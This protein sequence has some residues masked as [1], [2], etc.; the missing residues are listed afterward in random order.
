MRLSLKGELLE[1]ADP[2]AV[3]A[4]C[5]AGATMI[6]NTIHLFDE[7]IGRFAAEL[8]TDLS[9]PVNVNMYLSQ[10]SRPAFNRH[11]DIHDV[12]I[13]QIDGHKGWAVYDPTVNFPLFEMKFHGAVPPTEPRIETEL[14]PGDVLYIPRGHWHEATA[15]EDQSLHLT[16]GIDA[17]TGIDFLTWVINELREDADCRAPF[18]LV[19]REEERTEQAYD[20]RRA[21][22]R[23]VQERLTQK[24]TSP[25]TFAEYF[26]FKTA[27]DR[28]ATRFSLPDQLLESPAR[29]LGLTRFVRPSYQ[30]VVV[31]FDEGSSELVLTVWGKV[32]RLPIAAQ[33][34]VSM[35]FARSAFSFE[36]CRAAVPDLSDDETWMVV[37][38]FVREAIVFDAE[39]ERWCEPTRNA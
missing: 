6:I 37:N 10:P 7:K 25:T 15:T 32:L 5:R 17:H 3:I 23:R 16:V 18:P 34:L 13:L 30:R 39:R 14:S 26:K 27:S 24:L 29:Q 31:E 36:E 12:F 33:A 4:Q 35:I 8:S 1:A 9:E 19:L 2:I 38:A 11:Y 21:F 22:L 20:V 28:G